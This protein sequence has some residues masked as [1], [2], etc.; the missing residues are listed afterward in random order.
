MGMQEKKSR[1]HLAGWQRVNMS[2]TTSFLGLRLRIL[3]QTVHEPFAIIVNSLSTNVIV[4]Q[5]G[6]LLGQQTPPASYEI[7]IEQLHR[8][9]LNQTSNVIGC[10]SDDVID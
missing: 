3:S 4:Q 7:K 5:E 6:K 1:P 10:Q 2:S 9:L 8:L